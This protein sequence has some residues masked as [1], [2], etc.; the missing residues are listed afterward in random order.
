[1]AKYR[2]DLMEHIWATRRNL[3]V[4]RIEVTE[5][6]SGGQKG[7]LK[8]RPYVMALGRWGGNI[9][10]DCWKSRDWPVL[11]SRGWGWG[12]PPAADASVVGCC[13]RAGQVSPLGWTLTFS[14]DPDAPTGPQDV[15][16][17][18]C[19]ACWTLGASFLGAFAQMLP[20]SGLC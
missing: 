16:G 5:G 9:K 20:S 19:W 3:E 1:M 2:W 10:G 12:P 17:A 18:G 15:Q 8:T 4:V 6:V 7:D 14:E 13:T 11:K